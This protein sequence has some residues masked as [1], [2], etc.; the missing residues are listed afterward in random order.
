MVWP[1]N[2]LKLPCARVYVK[3]RVYCLFM[4]TMSILKFFLETLSKILIK[5]SSAQPRSHLGWWSLFSPGSSKP[6]PLWI[7]LALSSESP[8]PLM[9]LPH[10]L[11]IF[12]NPFSSIRCWSCLNLSFLVILIP[13]LWGSWRCFIDFISKQC[14]LLVQWIMLLTLV[15]SCLG[16]LPILI[17]WL[18]P[19]ISTLV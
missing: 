9:I 11:V 13:L 17:S 12:Y 2:Q 1:L 15:L 5:F 16:K 10:Y 6:L 14:I 19:L 18:V 7:M 8:D 3:K 4:Q